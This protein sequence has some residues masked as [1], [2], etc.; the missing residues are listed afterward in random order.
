MT[1]S[2]LLPV[3]VPITMGII[4]WAITVER[5][6]TQLQDMAKDIHAIRTLLEP[7]GNLVSLP[8]LLRVG[9]MDRRDD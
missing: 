6:I 1:L 4:A 2:T 7:L 8:S 3:F 9:K 5:R